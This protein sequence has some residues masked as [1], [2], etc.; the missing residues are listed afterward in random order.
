MHFVNHQYSKLNTNHKESVNMKDCTTQKEDPNK[1]TTQVTFETTPVQYCKYLISNNKSNPSDFFKAVQENVSYTFTDL[2]ENTEAVKLFSGSERRNFL[3]GLLCKDNQYKGVL[4]DK[5]IPEEICDSEA[6]ADDNVLNIALQKMLHYLKNKRTLDFRFAITADTIVELPDGNWIGKLNGSHDR[7]M[8]NDPAVKLKHHVDMGS[9]SPLKVHTASVLIDFYEKKI[10]LVT[11]TALVDF[12]SLDTLVNLPCTDGSDSSAITVNKVITNYANNG[13]C[14]GKAGGFDVRDKEIMACIRKIT[15]DPTTVIGLPCAKIG[16][17][18]PGSIKVISIIENIWKYESFRNKIVHHDV[19]R[20]LMLSYRNLRDEYPNHIEKSAISFPYT[21]LL[22]SRELSSI[23]DAHYPKSEFRIVSTNKK[24]PR[25]ELFYRLFGSATDIKWCPYSNKEDFSPSE[26]NF[27]SAVQD[28]IL[29]NTALQKGV[30]YLNEN[31]Q[32]DF[33]DK[34]ELIISQ[35]TRM[36]ISGTLVK[37]AAKELN[38]SDFIDKFIQK[39]F[40]NGISV[41]TGISLIN[42]GR[43]LSESNVAEILETLREKGKYLNVPSLKNMLQRENIVDRKMRIIIE[44]EVLAR[45]TLLDANIKKYLIGILSN[46]LFQV[47]LGYGKSWVYF[48]RPQDKI[49]RDDCSILLDLLKTEPLKYLNLLELDI[50]DYL[51]FNYIKDALTYDSKNTFATMYDEVQRSKDGYPDDSTPEGWERYLKN[52]VIT[53]DKLTDLKKNICHIADKLSVDNLTF[54]NISYRLVLQSYLK[55]YKHVNKTGGL[56]IQDRDLFVCISRVEG[57]PFTIV[58][59]PIEIMF[60]LLH[61]FS[62]E[63][64]ISPMEL[65]NAY[66]PHKTEYRKIRNESQRML[67]NR[68]NLWN[69]FENVV[70]DHGSLEKYGWQ[71]DDLDVAKEGL[72]FIKILYSVNNRKELSEINNNLIDNLRMT[73]SPLINDFKK[74]CYSLKKIIE[75]DHSEDKDLLDMSNQ[76]KLAIARIIDDMGNLLYP[77]KISNSAISAY[78]ELTPEMRLVLN[79][80]GKFKLQIDPVCIDFKKLH[81]AAVKAPKIEEGIEIFREFLEHIDSSV[82]TFFSGNTN[83]DI[84]TSSTP[85]NE[86][87]YFNRMKDEFD[88]K[89]YEILQNVFKSINNAFLRILQANE[90]CH[91]VDN[92]P[93][94]ANDWKSFKNYISNEL[95]TTDDKKSIIVICLGNNGIET[96]MSLFIARLLLRFGFKV[97]IVVKSKPTLELDCT[98]IDIELIL[99]YFE[100][101][102]NNRFNRNIDGLLKPILY[103]QNKERLKIIEADNYAELINFY[104]EVD[105]NI[106]CLFIGEVWYT[107]VV[108]IDE[109]KEPPYIKIGKG[110]CTGYSLHVHK[111]RKKPLSVMNQKIFTKKGVFIAPELITGWYVSQIFRPLVDDKDPVGWKTCTK[112]YELNTNESDT[113]LIN[114]VRE[115]KDFFEMTLKKECKAYAGLN[116][117]PETRL[118]VDS[119]PVWFTYKS[120]HKFITVIVNSRSITITVLMEYDLL[121]IVRTGGTEWNTIKDKI[122]RLIVAVF[123]GMLCNKYAKTGSNNFYERFDFEVISKSRK[124]PNKQLFNT[125]VK[126]ENPDIPANVEYLYV[127]VLL[128]QNNGMPDGVEIRSRIYPAHLN[129]GK[130][131]VR[132]QKLFYK[133]KY[134]MIEEVAYFNKDSNDL[135]PLKISKPNFWKNPTPSVLISPDIA[136]NYIL[137]YCDSIPAEYTQ[138]KIS[139]CELTL[140]DIKQA[141]AIAGPIDTLTTCDKRVQFVRAIADKN[142]ERPIAFTELIR[143]GSIFLNTDLFFRTYW[144]DPNYLSGVPRMEISSEEGPVIFQLAGPH[145][146]PS[147]APDGIFNADGMDKNS[148]MAGTFSRAAQ[149]CLFAGAAAIDINMCCQPMYTQGGGTKLL[150]KEEHVLSYNIVKAVRDAVNKYTN[151]NILLSCKTRLLQKQDTG[152]FVVDEKESVEFYSSLFEN[153]ADWLT[154]ETRIINDGQGLLND[155][156]ARNKRHHLKSIIK[157]VCEE[158]NIKQKNI[159]PCFFL[160]G[161]IINNEDFNKIEEIGC[162]GA[163]VC[164]GLRVDNSIIQRCKKYFINPFQYQIETIESPEEKWPEVKNNIDKAKKYIAQIIRGHDCAN[165]D[166]RS[167]CTESNRCYYIALLVHECNRDRME[168]I[169]TRLTGHRLDI[170]N[171]LCNLI[172]KEHSLTKDLKNESI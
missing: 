7:S 70:K 44:K 150:E 66:W 45:K 67:L 28:S 54:T 165:C 129:D 25:S 2:P 127:K 135:I 76:D 109:L 169:A 14:S 62:I 52:T 60:K 41:T 15:G 75:K 144:S 10:H 33:E 96:M 160:N 32:I 19:G 103:Y 137:D 26:I 132:L 63:V 115:N 39:S 106:F 134:L 21:E 50:S 124:D 71:T 36:F 145:N 94:I 68:K 59:L 123:H 162:A 121:R 56:R 61:E 51:E 64:D 122:P 31:L 119:E 17:L 139:P 81:Y 49:S 29:V 155:N 172:L 3:M 27:S 112:E 72:F 6:N 158:Q 34:N 100:H 143:V 98:R 92:A 131:E 85:N 20:I 140:D 159:T 87:I 35:I 166:H 128:F 40:E 16:N 23:A 147:D 138:E 1:V 80:P 99:P 84:F 104:K 55:W 37:K 101:L 77:S 116:E 11:D 142:S 69:K 156:T 79:S 117:E 65:Y 146:L 13:Y 82:G 126:L 171:R 149:L 148:V 89:I 42:K 136:K 157:S 152:S 58:G 114:I 113:N 102:V 154:V 18:I 38:E 86:H 73:T 57:D 74:N 46:D 107:E 8:D 108:G 47:K 161:E 30:E 91:S 90:I 130:I 118:K 120:P 43:F 48:N 9:N 125:K 5:N 168:Y 4:K 164:M 97:N 24:G 163:V 151:K 78:R 167:I 12:F 105:G 110:I 88:N 133:T 22:V 93:F 95:S 53:I 83:F 141:R 170:F 153:G 111:N